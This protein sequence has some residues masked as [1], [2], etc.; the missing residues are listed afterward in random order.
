MLL[1]QIDYQLTTSQL[2]IQGGVYG[3]SNW[4]FIPDYSNNVW[5]TGVDFTLWLTMR[6]LRD[7]TGIV[8]LALYIIS[9]CHDEIKEN[10]SKRREAK[11]L[12]IKNKLANAA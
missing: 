6:L 9:K 2:E 10:E 12:L 11:F 4:F 5:E 8:V 7:Y 1:N 3:F